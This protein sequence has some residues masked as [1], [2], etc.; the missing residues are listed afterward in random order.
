MTELK[1]AAN[2]NHEWYEHHLSHALTPEIR[3]W[4]ESYTQ[5]K[6]T[7]L[8]THLYRQVR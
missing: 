6:G 4:W 2:T 1:K 7:D 3:Q 8:D 5:L